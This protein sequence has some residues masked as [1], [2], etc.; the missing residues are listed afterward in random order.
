MEQQQR[1]AAVVLLYPLATLLL[2]CLLWPAG[3]TNKSLLWD[4]IR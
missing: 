2:L 4:S 1:Q 3:C